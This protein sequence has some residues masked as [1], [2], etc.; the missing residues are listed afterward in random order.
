M[1]EGDFNS[2]MSHESQSHS[3]NLNRQ[4]SHVRFVIVGNICMHKIFSQQPKE[5]QVSE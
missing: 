1:F 2:Q 4:D 3:L 5:P